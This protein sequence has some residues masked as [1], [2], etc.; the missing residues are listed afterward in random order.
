MGSTSPSSL[1]LKTTLGYDIWG[2]PIGWSQHAPKGCF[3]FW[4]G[5]GLWISIKFPNSSHLIPLVTINNPSK[6]FILIK[7]PNF[8]ST[9]SWSFH[10]SSKFFCFHQFPLFPSSSCNFL[11]FSTQHYINPH[12]ALN[13]AINSFLRNLETW[14][15][16]WCHGEKKKKKEKWLT[17]FSGETQYMYSVQ[18]ENGYGGCT[19]SASRIKQLSTKVNR[20]IREKVG[21]SAKRSLA[22]HGQGGRG[23]YSGSQTSARCGRAKRWISA[24]QG[25]WK[26]AGRSASRAADCRTSS[27]MCRRVEGLLL[28]IRR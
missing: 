1:S 22:V 27:F 23:S 11:L 25:L 21:Q 5:G 17:F 2:E 18:W 3:L 9:S 7:F 6:P 28:Q 13:F 8:S 4:R 19:A 15:L 14:L 12:K 16:R 10:N 24:C 26:M 20:E